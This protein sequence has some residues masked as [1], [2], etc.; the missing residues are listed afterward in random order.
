MLQAQ[1]IMTPQPVTCR[2]HETANAAAH[3][4]WTHDIGSLPVTDANGRVVGM[5]TDRDIA[6]AAYTQGRPLERIGIAS[7]VSEEVYAVGPTAS[8]DEIEH[9]MRQRQVHRVP[10]VDDDGRAIGVVS[11]NDLA[12]ESEG[13]TRKREVAAT[14]RSIYM[15][16]VAQR[17]P[18][19]AAQ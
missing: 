11:L 6:M 5:L 4:M 17:P 15:G 8:I 19:A 3:A 13:S 14:L 9:V 1:D 18:A 16:R 10:V 12:R 2:I 7:A